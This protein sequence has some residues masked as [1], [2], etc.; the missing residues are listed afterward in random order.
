MAK[1]KICGLTRLEDIIA[2]NEC[3]PDYVGFVFAES[4]RRVGVEQAKTLRVALNE[5]IRAVGVFVN[6][7][8]AKIADIYR[9]NIVDL[10][11][12]HGDE[13]DNYI[14][15]L[16]KLVDAPI[17]KAIAVR[18]GACLS[19][20]ADYCLYDTYCGIMRG[21]S[22]K[23]FDWQAVSNIEGNFFLAGGLG[24]TNVESAIRA[25]NPYCVDVSSGVEIDGRKDA[26]KM[27]NIVSIVREV[28]I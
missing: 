2:A 25:V 11:Q 1:I 12:L 15:E 18:D 28:R 8:I 7:D 20:A 4:K 24:C 6:E 13:N 17:I 19:S 26:N 9:Q 3:S 10:I 5:G 16:R 22:G 27:K 23:S 14:K 21:G